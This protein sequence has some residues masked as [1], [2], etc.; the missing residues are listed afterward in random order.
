[1]TLVMN[2]LLYAKLIELEVEEEKT[3]EPEETHEETTM[4]LWDCVPTLEL[5][6]EE[7]T[8]EIQLSS[9]NVTT[10]SKGPVMDES[11]V[12]PKIKNM[13]ENMNKIIST[14]QTKSKSDRRLT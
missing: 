13:Q 12:L 6:E 11:S 5:N 14:T 3:N 7:P 4:V 1:M 9:V 8:E 10:R 2:Q